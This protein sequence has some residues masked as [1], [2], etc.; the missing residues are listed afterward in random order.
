MRAVYVLNGTSLC[1]GVRV[2]Y[3][4]A[5]IL[6]ERGI[7][8]EVVSPEP[9]SSWAPESYVFYRQVPALEPEFIG[10]ADIAIGTFYFTMR[11]VMR[12]AG[13]IPFH[14]C[15]GYEGLYEPFRSQW[16]EIESV[17]RL[18]SK[19]LV[20][21]P[22]LADLIHTRFGQE[23]A[24]IPQPFDANVFT[25]K[26][27]RV[28]DGTFRILL[29]GQ[30]SVPVK[31]IAWAFEALRPLEAEIPGL[32]IV[33]LSQDAP[34]EEITSWPHAERHVA[35]SPSQVP[36]IYRGVDVFLGASNHVEGFGLPTLE[37]MS[38]EIPC[39]LTDIGAFR[40]IDPG[41]R[42]SLRIPERDGEAL[43]AAVRLLE[44]DRDLRERLGRAGRAIAMTYNT[45]RTGAALAAAFVQALNQRSSSLEKKA[46][47]WLGE[48]LWPR[49]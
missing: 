22:Y 25:P 11:P 40:D 4:H 7:Q 8:A 47:G 12:M 36:E 10:P 29:A 39:I 48:K 38:T 23:A 21:S 27:P 17:Y 34:E 3:Q 46:F 43:R 28:P 26:K 14:F 18:P 41:G 15:Q 33:R 16:P 35:V 45:S 42:A 24:F 19:K 9:P 32:T 20:V 30:W 2:V 1:G 37:A 6:R 13:A 44:S 31:G 5:A 49:R